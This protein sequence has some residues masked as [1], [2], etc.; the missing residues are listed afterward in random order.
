M[1]VP[2]TV[3]MWDAGS[4]EPLPYY[5][6]PSGVNSVAW[7]PDSQHIAA[8]IFNT[9]QVWETTTGKAVLT[10]QGHSD[11]VWSV[12]WSPDGTHT[13]SGSGSFTG[14]DYTVQIWDATN[15]KTLSTYRGHTNIVETVTWS[16]DSQ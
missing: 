8:A 15:G 1:G 12:A 2:G 5:T 7:S 16:P 9:V 14:S 13:A 10:Y 6:M 3:L 4:V 11:S